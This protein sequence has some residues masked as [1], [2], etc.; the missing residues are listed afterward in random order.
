MTV[1]LCR[2]KMVRG[3]TAKHNFLTY[4]TDTWPV[5]VLNSKFSSESGPI[6]EFD[7][8]REER[9]TRLKKLKHASAQGPVDWGW[10]AQVQRR[11][12]CSVARLDHMLYCLIS[13]GKGSLF[14]LTSLSE[15]HKR[16]FKVGGSAG[17]SLALPLSNACREEAKGSVA[18]IQ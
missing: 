8:A 6:N 15:N 3:L 13:I 1:K 5:V 9:H 12:H 11:G 10:E 14:I 16:A 17:S 18:K 2:N 4:N 7:K